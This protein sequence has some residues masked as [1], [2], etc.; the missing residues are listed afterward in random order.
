PQS[1]LIWF[2]ESASYFLPFDFLMTRLDQIGVRNL[3]MHEAPAIKASARA[4]KAIE[5]A[6]DILSQTLPKSAF[7]A[8]DGTV[9]YPLRDHLLRAGLTGEDIRLECFFNNPERKVPA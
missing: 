8:G 6:D 4:A 2:A 5:L 9:I 1:K 3:A 7:L